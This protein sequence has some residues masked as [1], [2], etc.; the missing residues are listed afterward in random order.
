[1]FSEVLQTN[2]DKITEPTLCQECGGRSFRLLK[3]ESEFGD[4]QIVTIQESHEQ[5]TGKQQPRQMKVIIKDDL[6]DLVA[7]GELI[8][9]TGI[10]DCQKKEKTPM[11][12]FFL[13]GNNVETLEKEY[14]EVKLTPEDKRQILELS[15]DPNLYQKIIDSTAPVIEGFELFK[16]AVALQLF[17]GSDVEFED[18]DA[19]V[20]SNIHILIM[21]DPGIGKSQVLKYISKVAPGGIYT[22]GKGSSGVGLTAAAVSDDMGGWTL[23]AGALVLG[24]K[25]FVCIDEFDKM[26]QD[27]R[28]SIHEALEQGTITIYKAGIQATLMARCSVLAAATPNSA[29]STPISQ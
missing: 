13:Q 4:L 10:L 25:G 3:E 29:D 20:R 27:D 14:E 17:G 24:D 22:S 21:G 6:C 12:E 11:M 26:R 8:R 18:S 5:L 16:E 19:S 7:P 15:K 9:V 28:D 23:E 2:H 1:M